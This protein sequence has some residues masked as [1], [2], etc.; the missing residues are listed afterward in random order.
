MIIISSKSS[1]CWP[2]C[3]D[4]PWR[5]LE[6]GG[7]RYCWWGET[8]GSSI[9]RRGNLA[10]MPTC[11]FD[12]CRFHLRILQAQGLAETSLHSL[13]LVDLSRVRKWAQ[14]DE[15]LWIQ[16]HMYRIATSDLL[17]SS[18]E[19]PFPRRYRISE[20]RCPSAAVHQLL[21]SQGARPCAWR[22]RI[23]GLRRTVS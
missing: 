4:R 1:F 21:D 13:N 10:L 7:L 8:V 22:W 23:V 17:V 19:L 11:R 2:N 16:I 6:E 12:V 3:G 15:L 14:V 18:C 9:E 5:R 20:Q